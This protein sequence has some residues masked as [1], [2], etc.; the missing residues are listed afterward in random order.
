MKISCRAKEVVCQWEMLLLLLLTRPD[1]EHALLNSKGAAA[2]E[3]ARC[4]L[5][6]DWISETCLESVFKIA[7]CNS[8]LSQG[9]RYNV[10]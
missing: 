3:K 1:T 2:R 4:F 9:R 8:G 7:L 6:D 10:D 5:L